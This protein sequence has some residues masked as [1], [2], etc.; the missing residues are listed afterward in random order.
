MLK[1]TKIMMN[2]RNAREV[3]MKVK[4]GYVTLYIINGSSSLSNLS[5]PVLL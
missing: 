3:A 5:H 1:P 2:V 4:S